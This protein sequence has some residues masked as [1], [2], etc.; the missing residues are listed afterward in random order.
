MDET[1]TMETG[2]SWYAVHIRSRHEFVAS[3]E[4]RRKGIEAFLPS[5]IK[6]RQW[7]DRKKRVQFAL[8][9]GYLFV[10]VSPGNEDYRSVQKTKGV[11]AF[12]CL[13]KSSPTLVPQEEMA[14]L[15]AML[16]SGSELDIYPHLRDGARVRVKKGPLGDAV[17]ILDRSGSRHLFVVNIE[18]LGRSVGVEVSPEDIEAA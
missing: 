16:E 18:I 13:D 9:P 12:V 17:G 14:A 10:R 8:F 3:G 5:V 11:V 6:T 7:K 2:R 1:R 4:L 15:R